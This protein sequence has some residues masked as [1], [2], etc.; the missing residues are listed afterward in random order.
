MPHPDT[1]YLIDI[2]EAAQLVQTFVEGIDRETFEQD[3]MRQSAVVRQIEVI[4]EATKRLSE[5]FRANHPEIPWRK[6]AGMRDVLI[7]AY[8]RVDSDEVWHTATIAI[9]T[10]IEK[11]SPLI[12]RSNSAAR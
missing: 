6:M 2:F 10:L 4:G 5:E 1:S 9:P 12:P 11:I 3:L 7:H 8:D